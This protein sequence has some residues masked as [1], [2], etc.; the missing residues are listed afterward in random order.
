MAD[1]EFIECGSLSISY[2]VL[3]LASVSF[4]V[5]TNF[6]SNP[7]EDTIQNYTT[8]TV[9]DLTFT[10]YI[11]GVSLKPILGTSWYEWGMSLVMTSE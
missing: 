1:I 6:L 2:D 3:G 10:G 9:G 8:L 5:V 4:T 7:A 11:T